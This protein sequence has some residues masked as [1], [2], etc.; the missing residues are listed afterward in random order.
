MKEWRKWE[1]DMCI[2]AIVSMLASCDEGVPCKV[3]L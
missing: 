2:A 3:F 1:G